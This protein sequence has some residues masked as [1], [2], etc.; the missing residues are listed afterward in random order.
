MKKILSIL[1]CGVFLAS[2]SACT[3]LDLDDPN[4]IS[5]QVYV[6][7]VAFNK[8]TNKM[9]ITNNVNKVKQF[10]RE[11][12]NTEEWTA[13]CYAASEGNK[14]FDAKG[15]PEF[16]QIFMLNF[17]DGTDNW[18][19]T[20]WGNEGR[21]VPPNQV[22][23]TCRSDLSKRAGLNS[24][25]L[26]FGNDKD[27]RDDLKT[28]VMGSGIYKNAQ[29]QSQ[30]Q[31][32][33][34]EIA[35]SMISSAKNVVL[36]THSGYFYEDS[37]KYFRLSFT[38]QSVSD[39]IY[40]KMVGTPK[41]GYTLTITQKGK[42]A[43][44]DSPVHAKDKDGKVDF[45]LRNLKFVY[46][47][48]EIAYGFKV[49]VSY[50][51]KKYYDEV[52]ATYTSETVSKK[53]AVVLVLDCSKSMGS[54]FGPMQE[55]A[56]G[57]IETLTSMGNNSSKDVDGFEMGHAYVDLG[58]PSRTLWATCNIGA[59]QP[60]E[61]GNFYAWGETSPKSDY[62]EKNYKFYNSATRGEYTK[63]NSTDNKTILESID[64][65]ASVNWKGKWR[66]PTRD[67]L[68][69]LQNNCKWVWTRR[70]GINGCQITGP[71]GKNIFLPAAGFM[72]EGQ[73][74]DRTEIGEYWPSTD[75]GYGFA[76]DSYSV[77]Y[78]ASA[79]RVSGRSI[80]PVCSL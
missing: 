79:F 69:E 43:Q 19:N 3:G 25:A 51:G 29:S 77:Y 74:Y 17:S 76:F 75:P 52:E 36:T 44:F 1:L 21:S 62:T 4:S 50:D 56:V 67:E 73:L 53:I 9:P 22:Y 32:T 42:Y 80:R 5:D 46:N 15:L 11:Q 68:T 65:A 63:Y 45:P 41:D 60:E 54:A 47:N 12:T 27:F 10:I 7:V 18:S 66:M 55:A 64:D 58:L 30:L 24:Y 57:L 40:A 31:S 28:L 13:F 2:F 20:L 38:T 8:T 6:G 37:P 39:V 14:M 59:E 72:S 61:Y 33:F 16:D 23:E 35:K 26:G 71:N 78:N 34:N 48:E 49:D 70:N